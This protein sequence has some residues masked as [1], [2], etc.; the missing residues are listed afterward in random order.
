MKHLLR[1]LAVL[2]LAAAVFS[3]AAAEADDLDRTKY[4]KVLAYIKENQPMEFD[5]GQTKFSIKQLKKLMAEMPEGSKFKFTIW[6]C[7]SWIDSESEVLNLDNGKAKVTEAD[8]RWF[9]TNMPN[10]KEVYSFE[11]REL[12]NKI[13]PPMMEEYPDIQF[14]WYVYISSQYRLRSDAT[15]FSTR[16]TPETK[17]RL[18]EKTFENLKYVP[19]LKALD[20]GHNAVKDISWLKYLPELRI[21]ILADNDIKDIS[22]IAQLE[23]LEYL[24]LF[25]NDI[26]DV[27]PLAGLTNLIDLN[28]CR[29]KLADTDLSV[30]DD[31]NLERFWCTRAKV[32]EEAQQR[33]IEANPETL[34]N[35]TKG[36]CTDHGWRDIY[37][38]KQILI[39][40][41][42]R[43]WEPFADPAAQ[44]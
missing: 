6:Y 2:L 24:E 10:V 28:L 4:N 37:R 30:L 22:P 25:M 42:D 19:G 35:F 27:T 31:L 39:M 12:D 14:N 36:D 26:S 18:T 44:K 9:L 38:H 41:R 32:S 17:I 40:F 3:F 5:M 21:L 1:I 7:N 23:H 16:K 8:L 20:I 33:F 13:I 34:C 43:V 15:A 29:T 11:H